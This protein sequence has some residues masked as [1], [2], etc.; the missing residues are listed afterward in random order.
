MLS[1][2]QD[3]AEMTE[4]GQGTAVS[5]KQ[6]IDPAQSHP[7]PSLSPRIEMSLYNKYNSMSYK[8]VKEECTRLGISCYGLHQEYVKKLVSYEMERRVSLLLAVC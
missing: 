5:P 3:P 1:G 2:L 8:D 6:V 4:E 7:C